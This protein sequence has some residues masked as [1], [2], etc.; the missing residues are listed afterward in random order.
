MGIRINAQL[1][2][3]YMASRGY[4][5]V[6]PDLFRGDSLT[7]AVFEP[8]SGFD[9]QAWFAKHGTDAVDPVI[10]STIKMLR[11]EHGI[12]KLGGVGYCFGG[13]VWKQNDCMALS[14]NLMI[15]TCFCSMYADS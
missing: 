13:K 14:M 15:L 10:E 1:L 8:N 12:E 2:A 6:I 4:L 5:T 3:D 9:R 7:P 11:D